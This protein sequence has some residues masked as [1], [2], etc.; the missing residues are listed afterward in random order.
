MNYVKVSDQMNAYIDRLVFRMVTL[1]QMLIGLLI[2]GALMPMRAISEEVFSNGGMEEWIHYKAKPGQRFPELPSSEVPVDVRPEVEVLSPY[3]EEGDPVESV[4]A[5]DLTIKHSDATSLRLENRR[6]SDAVAAVVGPLKVKPSM[7]YRITAWIKGQDIIA[8]P[9]WTAGGVFLWT[10]FG[11]KEG[12]MSP[13]NQRVS[14]K[15]PTGLQRG[16]FDWTQI[17]FTVDTATNTEQLKIKLQLRMTSGTLWLDDL[18]IKQVGEVR[19]I[20]NF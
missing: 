7:R 20:P 11:P 10:H 4:L 2:I 19:S 9:K 5:R 1:K 16:T 17:E 3:G 8:N 18:E 12:F 15:L 13:E 14:Q 6:N